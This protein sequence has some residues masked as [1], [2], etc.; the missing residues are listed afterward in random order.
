[1]MRRNIKQTGTASSIPKGLLVSGIVGLL[2]T[3]AG[4]ALTA[5]LISTEKMDE[6]YIGYGVMVIILIS[7]YLSSIVAW[8]KI[9]H[10]RIMVCALAGCVYFCILLSIT[11]LFFGGQFSAVGETALLILCGSMLAVIHKP[12]QKNGLSYQGFQKAHR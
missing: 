8:I 6:T 11:A 12:I 7:S 4:S 9:K 1:M 2:T 10:R 5:L 3:L